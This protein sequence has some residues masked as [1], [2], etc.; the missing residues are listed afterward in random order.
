MRFLAIY[1]LMQVLFHKG[2]C[3]F[4]ASNRKF[5]ETQCFGLSPQITGGFLHYVL[6]ICKDRL[7]SRFVQVSQI[8]MVVFSHKLQPKIWLL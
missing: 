1:G 3:T 7:K 5:S 4:L 2:L 6:Y 8:G